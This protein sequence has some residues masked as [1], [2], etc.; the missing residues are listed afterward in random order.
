M[1]RCQSS[2]NGFASEI[3]SVSHSRSGKVL[4]LVAVLIPAIFGMAAV[5][6]DGGFLMLL[7]RKYQHATDAAAT[8]AAYNVALDA[9]SP[10]ATAGRYV[11]E[12][13]DLPGASVTLNAPP[14]GGA[15]AGRAGYVEVLAE[16]SYSPRF[17]PAAGI[18]KNLV[19]RSRSVAGLEAAGFGVHV[20]DGTYFVTTDIRPFGER[21][22]MV[23]CRA[24]PE[25]VGV[26]AIPA[27]VLY[28]DVEE[29][30]QLVRFA[31][32]KRTEV[33]EDAVERLS[34]LAAS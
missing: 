18:G 25:R 27:V 5:V 16:E 9:G 6:I 22:G 13:N 28:D 14:T 24:L 3:L 32:C 20:P 11:R 26:V 4:V 33:L 12:I 7:C 31:F 19:V 23:F 34:K 15:Y 2:T 8:A 30:S 1:I 10:S 21:D 17:A 29:G